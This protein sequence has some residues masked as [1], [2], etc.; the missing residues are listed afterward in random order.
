MCEGLE[1][2]LGG[3]G[4]E[5]GMGYGSGKASGGHWVQYDLVLDR[6]RERPACLWS[7]VSHKKSSSI[8]Y[9]TT[10]DNSIYVIRREQLHIMIHI[11]LASIKSNLNCLT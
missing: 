3:Q 4:R 11:T 5:R 2:G 8:S 6:P 7:A 9:S 1:R 10:R